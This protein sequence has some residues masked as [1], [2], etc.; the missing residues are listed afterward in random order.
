MSFRSCSLFLC[1]VLSACSVKEDRTSCPCTVRLVIA[2]FFKDGVVFGESAARVCRWQVAGTEGEP[3]VEGGAVLQEVP[4]TIA[5]EVPRREA[6][7]TVWLV[8]DAGDVTDGGLVIREGSACP[9][10]YFFSA[11]VDCRAEEAGVEVL[12]HQAFARLAC[13]LKNA[14]VLGGGGWYEVSG[15]VCG[16]GPGGEPLAGPFRCPLTVRRTAA[17]GVLAAAVLPRQR[18]AGLRLDVYSADRSILRSFAVGEYIA[19]S[20][21][22]WTAPDLDDI[23]LEIDLASTAVRLLRDSDLPEY[24]RTLVL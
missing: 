16:Y 9:E 18:D 20:G 21:Y 7:V 6:Q 5:L 2:G 19:A 14:S 17:G 1:L 23:Y 11:G 12:F 4:Q 13:V 10:L 22:D 8:E 15:G 3:G 24:T